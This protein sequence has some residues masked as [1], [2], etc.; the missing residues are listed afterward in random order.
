MIDEADAHS[1][2]HQIAAGFALGVPGSLIPVA[3]GAMGRVWRLDTDRGAFAVK[4]SLWAEDPE[5][6]L[7]Q[8]EFSACVGRAGSQ[9]GHPGSAR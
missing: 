9:R 6:F 4:E 8:L 2:A 3:Q 7:A 5:T 1:I